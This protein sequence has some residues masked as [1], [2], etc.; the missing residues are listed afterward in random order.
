MVA[1]AGGVVT[2]ETEAVLDRLATLSP[3]DPGLLYHRGLLE[4]QVGRPDRAFPLWEAVI[5]SDPPDGLHRTLALAQ[6][7]DLA[8]LAG[9][10][11]T[12]PEA[13]PASAAPGPTAADVA[14]AAAMDEA[15]RQAMIRGMVDGLASRLDA[16]GGPAADWARLVTA[17][18]IL[19]D[20]VAAR[21]ALERARLALAD[22]A[23]APAILDE[24]ARQAGV[25]G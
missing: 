17:L 13:P 20:D 19:G 8:W 14:D 22:D 3:D 2:V 11:W 21:A 16:E 4:A 6:M 24:A 18:A 10:D 7:A 12:E 25:A 23:G 5:A 1:A 9:R 15:D